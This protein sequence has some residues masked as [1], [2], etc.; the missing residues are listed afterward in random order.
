VDSGRIN[1]KAP[2]SY[3]SPLPQRSVYHYHNDYYPSHRIFYWVTWPNCC[4]PICYTWGPRYTFGFFW[5]YYHR[6]FIFVSIGGYWPCYTYRRYY[7]YG[8]HPYAWYG[9]WPPEYVIAGDTYNYYYYNE[10]PPQSQAV[11]EAQKKLDENPP[12]EPAQE[13]PADRNFDQAVKAFGAGEYAAATAKF[14]DAQQLSP[15]DI[16]LPFAHAQALFAGGEYTKSAEVLRGALAKSSPDKEGVF[17]PRGL[18]SDQTVLQGQIEQLAEKIKQSEPDADLE[19]LL[20]YQ[21]LGTGK[22]DEAASHLQNARL[23]ADNTQAATVLLNL[24]EKLQK[25][26]N[27][28]SPATKQQEPPS[29]NPQPQSTEMK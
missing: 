28:T 25:P 11:A 6:R 26:D 24:L 17:Y 29:A 20:G 10:K 1:R 16:V 7:W 27:A 4:R 9:Y 8:C 2:Y 5:P 14:H 15:D 19:L 12:A 21:L 23:N 22:H 13:T 3:D 18:Y